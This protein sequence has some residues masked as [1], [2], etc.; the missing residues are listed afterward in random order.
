MAQNS[1]IAIGAVALLSLIIPAIASADVTYIYTGEPEADYKGTQLQGDSLS[2]SFTTPAL[3]PPDL[4]IGPGAPRYSVPVVSWSGSIGSYYFGSNTLDGPIGHL[5]GLYSLQF[6]TDNTGFITGWI[7]L[8]N[9]YTED[10]QHI[11]TFAS[12]G[13]TGSFFRTIYG[14]A[15]DF[16]QL[17]PSY[18]YGLFTDFAIAQ[19]CGSWSVN[20]EAAS[21]TPCPFEPP[22]PPPP[23][24]PPPPPP[25]PELSTWSI[26]LLGL[27][28]VGA[29][30]RRS[31]REPT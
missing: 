21:P 25:A 10:G 26:M 23:P 9:P 13:L 28:G 12:Q 18:L 15:S 1:C 17:N 2:F 30:L 27:S 3:L 5:L 29:M 24:T 20:G 7:F 19:T 22:P 4:S 8:G 14:D 11:I 6:D 31:R 16:V